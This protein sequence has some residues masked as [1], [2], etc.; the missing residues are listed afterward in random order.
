MAPLP[1]LEMTSK[2]PRSYLSAAIPEYV[3]SERLRLQSVATEISR[4]LSDRGAD[5]LGSSER[6]AMDA[7]LVLRHPDVL[8][9]ND[10]PK[11]VVDQLHSAAEITL[12]G[13]P[14]ERA[15]A[16]WVGRKWLGCTPRSQY[17]RDRLDIYAAIA[18]RDARAMLERARALLGG[19]AAGGDNWGRYLLST[20][21]LG[22]QAAGEHVEALRLW[23]A[24]RA[25]FYPRGDIPP[26]LIYLVT[27]QGEDSG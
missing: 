15:R 10:P 14:S 24:Y 26:Y 23:N 1:V 9:S 11:T 8:C 22:A 4:L 3:P 7:A 16:I 19:S 5:P 2:T 13:L 12:A 18:T 27:L 25:P 20:A 6:V 17:V 21:L